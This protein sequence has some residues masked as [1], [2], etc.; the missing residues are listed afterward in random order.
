MRNRARVIRAL[1]EREIAGYFS[2]PTGYVF[3]A[4]FVFL[5]AV[6]A[7]WQERFFAT[8]LANL[9]QLNALFPYLLV[10]FIP[11]VSMSLWAEEKKH[12]TEELLL[13][14]PASDFQVVLG[15]YLAGLSIYTV[16][17]L[18]SLS[19][20]AVLS[21][22]GNPD[23]GLMA[24]TYAGYWLMGAA[25]LALAMLASMV[26]DNLTVAFIL[27]SL[28]CA[29]PVFLDRAGA[30][31]SG[32]ARRLAERLS[33]VEQFR[34]LAA[35]VVTPH[36]LLYFGLFAAVALYANV[37][38]LGRRR[39]PSGR[40]A[41]RM[42]WHYL[43]RGISLVLIAASATLLAS[44]ARLRWDAT[45]EQIHS[46]S[47]E[48]RALLSGLSPRQ[49]VFIYAYLSPEVPRSYVDAR[50]NLVAMLR[51]FQAVGGEAVH[52]RI[53]ETVK[54]S[55]PAREA[56]E[57][58]NI[59]PYRVPVTEESARVANEIFLGMA[60]TCGSEEFVIPFLDRG[61][62][63]EYELM[64]SIRVVSRAQRRK[65]GILNT[66]A[67]LFGGFDYQTR[68]QS[69]DWSVV[70]ELRKQY[71]V[72]Q[73][74][75]DADYPAE[76]DALVAALPSALTQ[77]Q[78]DRLATWVKQGRPALVLLDPMPAF[79]LELAPQEIAQAPSP[80]A[81]PPAQTARA[82]LN[83]LLEAL[84]V[85]WQ[86]SRIV[87]DSHNPH[88]QLK[89]LPKEFVFVSKGFNQKE[90]VTAGLQE[91]VL[92]YPG[93]LKAAG[94]GGFVPLLESGSDSGTVRWQDLV[95]RSLFGVAV[96]QNLPHQ[97]DDQA[98]VLAA[99]VSGKANAI[100]VADVDLMG[101]QFFELR[102]RG[103]ENLNFDNVIFLL[104]AVDQLAGDPSFI[105]LRKRRPRHRTLEAVEARTRT[106]EAQRLR[107]TQLAEATAEQRLK[108]AQARLDRAVREVRQRPD[109]DDQTR[110][111]MISNLE[112][113]ENRRLTVARSTIEDEKQR[114]IEASRAEMENSIRGIQ[115]TIKLLAVALPPIPA[116]LV[117]VFVSVR[118]LRR[119][120]LG[121]P[122]D[123]LVEEGA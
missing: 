120:R 13:T 105:A 94:G 55:P 122:A 58:Y 119:E 29:V 48:T 91:L 109:L 51:E 87:W 84:G 68:A 114:Q 31:L 18:F 24:T 99:R 123:R 70:A 89:S 92:L 73:V 25:L 3:I 32:A 16:A 62:P 33:V 112:A 52:A 79:N 40:Q 97:P 4:L 95:Q 27:G 57:R 30:I 1:L 45:S 116:F 28:F 54:Y 104:N 75:P 78:V 21:W 2:T 80:F 42:G 22:L 50:N 64:R 20:V 115:N 37:A 63:V 12:G 49:P 69:Q 117:F 110:Q 41:P 100:V 82:N 26:T 8:N 90:P 107:E 38:L 121:A 111:I 67:K 47:H 56:L 98:H 43:A 59:R 14:L 65:V 71:E 39:W 85:S 93:E 118:R 77:P 88:P 11:A 36:A 17:L 35:G 34:D 5:S 60:F 76:I 66:P 10:F 23:P 74:S 61:L 15:K 53:I 83:P 7:F 102:R 19:H 46:L 96:N 106:Y 9:D 6:A 108:E 81:P 101:E 86:P 103:V 72:V 113:V 44:Q